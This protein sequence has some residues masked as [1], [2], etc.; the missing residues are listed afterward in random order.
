M[1]HPR[2][3]RQQELW[4]PTQCGCTKP[5]SAAAIIPFGKTC[6]VWFSFDSS[7]GLLYRLS[8][9]FDSTTNALIN[10][11]ETNQFVTRVRFTPQVSSRFIGWE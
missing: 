3:Q 11:F 4:L 5:I 9:V 10:T 1:R 2:P 6:P 7:A 8:Q